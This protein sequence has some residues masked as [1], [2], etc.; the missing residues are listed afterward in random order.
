MQQQIK[1]LKLLV[2]CADFSRRTGM[3]C[4]LK[5]LSRELIKQG[6]EVAI[7]APN[8]G[9]DDTIP[10]Y[11]F[12]NFKPSSIS[13]TPDALI[14]NEPL[15]AILLRHFPNIPAFN[16]IHSPTEW[17]TPIKNQRVRK[18]LAVKE[19][20][21]KYSMEQGV[22]KE[23]LRRINIPI[24]LDYFK[25]LPSYKN[26]WEFASI[27]TID[28]LRR[29]MLLDLIEKAKQGHTVLIAGKDWRSLGN[30]DQY[31]NIK[32]LTIV[33]EEI[34]DVR[35]YIAQSKY[36]C[37]LFIG[38]I[39]AEAWAMGKATIIYDK[40]GQI[41]K[42]LE[43]PPQDW[44]L[45]DAEKVAERLIEIVTEIEADIIIPHHN[46]ADMLAQL[47]PSIP[48]VGFNVIVAKFGGSFSV[49]CN[50]GAKLAKTD[51]LIFCNDDIIIKDVRALYG[52]IDNPADM[53]GCPTI[54]PDGRPQYIGIGYQ[55]MGEGFMRGKWHY[56]LAQ[57]KEDAIIPSGGLFRIRA[58]L[59][60]SAGQPK[61]SGFDEGYVNG[62]E[63][64]SLGLNVIAKG[65]SISFSDI[66]A[67]HFLSQSA[68]RF[69]NCAA[70]EKRMRAEFFDNL[71]F[72]SKIFNEKDYNLERPNSQK[73]VYPGRVAPPRRFP[74]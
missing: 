49:N 17:D 6:H 61:Y 21:V 51:T 7:V 68:G 23:K 29:P 40:S 34:A 45:H 37:G 12:S 39:T 1:K 66:P 52:M 58:S 2:G 33:A 57:T 19:E 73:I 35:P 71:D 56:Y 4:F 25:P 11:T 65:R 22:A 46:R 8:I 53:V 60:W 20:D 72:M 30:L 44:K 69:D 9:L 47:L 67:V 27:S 32:T 59:F 74:S 62:G 15:S 13:F 64:Q 28:A 18:Y 24:D 43:T 63:D 41:T 50:K 54:Y 55:V 5:T 14:L 48:T 31:K 42:T 70:G 3:P 10:C 36:I 16:I 26:R 38:T